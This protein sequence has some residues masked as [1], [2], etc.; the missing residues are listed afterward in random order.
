MITSPSESTSEITSP[1]GGESDK[2]SETN[3]ALPEG[4]SSSAVNETDTCDSKQSNEDG[5]PA[6]SDEAVV[7]VEDNVPKDSDTENSVPT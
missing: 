1:D 5:T 2:Q 4:D 6:T 7:E 3:T